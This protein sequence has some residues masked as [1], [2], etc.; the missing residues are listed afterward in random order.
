VTRAL[1]TQAFDSDPYR[2]S[3]FLENTNQKHVEVQFILSGMKHHAPGLWERAV[4]ATSA[5]AIYSMGAGNG[6]MEIPL[7]RELGSRRGRRSELSFFADDVSP[8][9]CAEFWDNAKA[10]DITK[11]LAGYDYK[12]VDFEDVGYTP[13]AADLSISSHVWYYLNEWRAGSGVNNSLLKFSR[14]IRPNG[15]GVIT[16]YSRRSDRY[17]LLAHHYELGGSQPEPPSDV[18]E[19]TLVELGAAPGVDYKDSWMD[20]SL[21]FKDG[22]F[23]PTEKGRALLSFMFRTDWNSLPAETR[24]SLGQ[25]LTRI[26]D[27]NGHLSLVLRDAYLWLGA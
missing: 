14:S 6:G 23:D 20:V 19:E 9:M 16:L 18:V 4:D 10:A 27:R 7:L 11:F 8:A 22:R 12:V 24:S 15:A 3:V 26:C 5:F 17:E 21:C 1:R 13:P 2:F 25:A